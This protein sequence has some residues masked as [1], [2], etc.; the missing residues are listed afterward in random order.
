MQITEQALRVLHH[1]L[2]LRPDHREPYRNHFVA[3]DG[4]HDMPA[5]DEL[6]KAGLMERRSTPAFCD[7]SDI[8]FVATEPGRNLALEMLPPE[9]KRT[10]FEEYIHA[11]CF[12]SF[13]EFLG[14]RK[15]KHE[16]RGDWRR[17]EYR[18]YRE[19]C[20]DGYYDMWRDVQ[21]DWAPTKKA[22]KASYKAALKANKQPPKGD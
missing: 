20:S 1:T 3:G 2:G 5:L 15:P 22:A 18:M 19:R 13:A 11:D 21:G 10:K 7:A 17:R 4:H 16:A 12:D 6:E 8:V 14:I 9:P